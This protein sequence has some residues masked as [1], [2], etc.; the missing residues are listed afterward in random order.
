MFSNVQDVAPPPGI[1]HPEKPSGVESL[2]PVAS[3]IAMVFVAPGACLSIYDPVHIGMSGCLAREVATTPPCIPGL[4]FA[5]GFEQNLSARR[6]STSTRFMIRPKEDDRKFTFSQ[7][8]RRIHHLVS[9]V[10]P[11]SSPLV[12]KPD[13]IQSRLP[14]GIRLEYPVPDDKEEVDFY[15]FDIGLTAGSKF[16]FVGLL[17]DGPTRGQVILRWTE[18]VSG[19]MLSSELLGDS[20]SDPGELDVPI[21][22][23]AEPED[24]LPP[25]EESASSDPAE[26]GDEHSYVEIFPNTIRPDQRFEPSHESHDAT[27]TL[28]RYARRDI[29]RLF[30]CFGILIMAIIMA[31]LIM[32]IVR[33]I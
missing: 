9:M 4:A 13:R 30:A 31:V 24:D 3:S 1:Q 22:D 14:S 21:Y 8:R 12:M 27:L 19:G 26:S 2:R 15:A 32:I 33:N 10:S 18:D 28:N 5:L 20:A 29:R 25:V 16:L 17:T 11:D 6:I 7:G 23:M